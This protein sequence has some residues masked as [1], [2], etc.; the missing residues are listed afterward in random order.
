MTRF[1]FRTSPIQLALILTAFAVVGFAQ[2]TTSEMAGRVTDQQGAPLAG[3]TVEAEHQ[4]TGTVYTAVT[5]SS[6]RYTLPLLRP[7]GP[8]RVRVISPGFT[9]QAR[10]DIQTT[11]GTTTTVDFSLSSAIAEQVTVQADSTFSEV[12][13]GAATNVTSEV[14]TRLP[15]IGRQLTDF[16]RLTPQYGGNGSFAGQDN[17]LNNITVDGS[18][19]NN[20]FGLAGQPGERTGVSPIS[21]AAVQEFQVSVAPFDVR[22]GNFVGADVNVVTKSGTNKYTGSAYYIWRNPGLVGKKAGD[23]PFSPGDFK[24]RTWGFTAGGP[25]PFF[26][27]GEHDG[28]TFISGR[29]KLFFFVNYEDELT[30]FPGTTFQACPG[31]GCRTGNVTRVLQSDLDTLRN[32]LRTNFNYDPGAYQGYGFDTPGK[33]FLLRGDYNINSSNRLTVRYMHLDSSTDVLM[34]NSSSLGFGN[35]RFPSQDALNFQN[36][37]YSILENIRSIV[38]EWTSIF[39]SNAA[40]S[41][42]VGYTKQD[43][44]RGAIDRLFPTVDILQSGVTYTSFGSEPFTPNNELRYNSFQIQDNLSIYR[45]SHTF[46]AGLSLERYES[47]N[48]FFPGSQSVYVYNSLAD[49]YADANG[50]LANPN[51]TTSPVTLRRFQVRWSNVPGL[52]KPIQP[53]EV[54]YPGFYGQDVWKVRENF[55]LTYGLRVDVPFFGETGFTN[56]Q[57]NGLAFRDETGQSVQYQTEKLPDPNLLWSPRVGFNWAP[58]AGKLQFRGG[59]GIFSGR[60]AYVWISNQIGENGILTGFEQLENTTARPWNPNPNRYKPATI[61]GA[62]ASSYALAV[63]DPK[64]RFPQLWRSNIAVDYRLPLGLIAGSEFLYS[65]DVNGIYYINANLPDPSTTFSGADNRPRWAAGNRIHSNITNNI[66]LKNQNVGRAWNLAFTLERPFAN[67]FYAKAAYSYGHAQN[68]VDPG[69]IAFGS[70]ST[71]PHAGNPNNPGLGFSSAMP[72]HRV[73]GAATYRAE[74]FKFGATTFSTFWESRTGGNSSYVF[75]GDLNGDGGTSNDLIYIHRDISEMNFA[76]ITTTSTTTTPATVLFTP[77]QQAAAWNAFIEQDPYLSKHR[78]EY[79]K[80]GAI[81]LPFVHRMDFSVAQDVFVKLG[82]HQHKFQ[83]R[84]DILNFGNLL[85]SNWG[86]GQSFVTTQPLVTATVVTNPLTNSTATCRTSAPQTTAT[87]CLRTIGGGLLTNSFTQTPSLNDVY[88]IQ[89][90]VRYFFN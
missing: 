29:D 38:G 24:F 15:T 17:R 45:G 7:G 56:P 63:T 35:R 60:P 83:I 55:T 80:R 40:N 78:G 32:Y 59:S 50:F 75:G 31:T 9:E 46:T 25:L 89:F 52:E 33:K 85:N 58:W 4:P 6:G 68:T 1:L 5:N 64:F 39:G 72:K 81:F 76:N 26:N 48:V 67:N 62:P 51:R 14:L 34:S 69:S 36:S 3:V 16:S 88:R 11:L 23:N 90:G 21:L 13:T 8:Y 30:T 47:E 66:V 18:Y 41:L 74:Y 2:I 70:W 61:T 42:L 27:F 82:G 43:E 10:E 73:F 87:Y 79:V 77:A 65:R 53:L 84:A 20:S 57:A 12:R 22:H 54:L 19:F 44:S 37:N 28:P 86:L 71:N 49:F